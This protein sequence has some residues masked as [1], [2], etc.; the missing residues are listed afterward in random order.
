[1]LDI[2]LKYN[3]KT[4]KAIANTRICPCCE[5]IYLKINLLSER[6]EG[7]SVYCKTCTNEQTLKRQR[8]L[9]EQ[10][11]QYKKGR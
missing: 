7:S 1:M 8:A 2:G 9:K 10:A 6:K 4:K 11:V 3:L 5:K